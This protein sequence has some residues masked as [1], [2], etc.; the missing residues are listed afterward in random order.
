MMMT[1][2]EINAIRELLTQ[3]NAAR[4]NLDMIKM[5]VLKYHSDIK[6]RIRRERRPEPRAWVLNAFE[7]EIYE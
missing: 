7:D 5:R 3:L 1:G 4:D 6:R 2:K